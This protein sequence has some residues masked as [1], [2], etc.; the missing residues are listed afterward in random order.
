MRPIKL[1]VQGLTAYHQPMPSGLLDDLRR[2]PAAQRTVLALHYDAGYSVAETAALVNAPVE[3]VRS[4]LRL[5]RER[6]RREHPEYG[7][8]DA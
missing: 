2:L 6:L 5:A 3:T 7:E 8:D 1:D 4:R